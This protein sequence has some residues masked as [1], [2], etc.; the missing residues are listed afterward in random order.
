MIRVHDIYD[1]LDRRFPFS[2]QMDYDNS[3]FLVGNPNNIVSGILLSL[4][5]T[6]DVLNEALERGCNLLVSHHPVIFNGLNCLTSDDSKSNLVYKLCRNDIS[7]ISLHTCL[8]VA[9]GGV[10][11]VLIR[12]L[13][14]ESAEYFDK[15]CLGRCGNL[16][17]PVDFQSF[18]LQIKTTLNNDG[19]RYY[20][21]DRPVFKI[22]VVGG[23]G[24]NYLREAFESG[25]DTFISSDIKYHQFLEAKSLGINIVDADHFCTENPV[26]Y[27]LLSVLSEEYVNLSICVSENHKAVISFY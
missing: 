20:S 22:A 10:N 5:I 16:I 6:E 24:G 14:V 23:A 18:L 8:D 11:D 17:N 3:G 12:L 9:C 7:V 25:C 19:L 27:S 4:D 1:Y 13:G 15:D 21:A 26:M 2:L